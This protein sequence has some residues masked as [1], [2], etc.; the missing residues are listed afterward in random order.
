MP[1]KEAFTQV[2]RHKAF[3]LSTLI[4]V[5]ALLALAAI[6]LWLPDAQAWVLALAAILA[7]AVIGGAACLLA[8]TLVFY[9]R[10]HSGEPA[11]LAPTLRDA[12][13]KL[14]GLLLWLSLTL[15]TGWL[16]TQ[17]KLAAWG[18]IVAAMLLLPIAARVAAEGFRG[19]LRNGWTLRY[20]ADSILFVAIGVYLPTKLI[21]WHPELGGVT[22]QTL[23][24]ALRFTAAILLATLSWLTMA[25]ILAAPKR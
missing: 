9:R 16:L 18:W 8:A 6:W 5:L 20:F 4:A 10:A 13:A 11:A 22:M 15:L 19:F 2:W 3:L 23:S 1:E 14:P 24:L 12:L 25:S 7:L 21:A 17:T